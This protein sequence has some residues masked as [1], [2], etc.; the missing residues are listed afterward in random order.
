MPLEKGGRIIGKATPRFAK[1]LSW[2]YANMAGE[3][4]CEDLLQ[5][6][7]VKVS[8]K[9]IQTVNERV[10][11]ILTEKEQ[12]CTYEIPVLAN[13]VRAIGIS[14]DGT[15][16][17]IKG[18]GYKETM[19]GTISLYD[20]AGERLHTIYT[21]CSPEH[22]KATFDYVFGQEI[23]RIQS[24]YPE[25]RYV[26]VADGEKGNWSFLTPYTDVQIIDFWHATEYLAG[27]AKSAYEDQ[28]ERDRWLTE[29]RS[30]LKNKKGSAA[31]LLKEMRKY[32]RDHFIDEKEHPVIRAVTYF[33]NHKS[34]MNYWQYQRNK[35][36]IGSGVVEAACKIL[37]KQRFS[38]S[39]SR[40]IRDTLDNILLARSLILTN[41][42]WVQ[43][44]NKLDRY[45]F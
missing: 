42:R 9:L 26:G 32:A 2:K 30:K 44:W 40:W 25:V 41:G 15:T 3:Q 1:M 22:G 34:K 16:S 31:K 14:R 5:H 6:H 21:G 11:A 29:S 17:P 28:S 37:V 27:Y 18:E 13:E 10:G 38:R 45:G 23:E 35:L 19:T 43:F 33:T 8:K 4:T 20:Q 12:K 7:G 24:K 39:G 36:P